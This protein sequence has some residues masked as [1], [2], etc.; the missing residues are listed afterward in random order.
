MYTRMF[1]NVYNTEVDTKLIT[2]VMYVGT[3]LHM[4]IE[5]LYNVY[6]NVLF[7]NMTNYDSYEI[8]III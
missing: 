3:Y 5:E 6:Y 1:G 4:N 7:H 2:C 8:N